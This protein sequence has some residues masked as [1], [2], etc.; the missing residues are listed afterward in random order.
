MGQHRLSRRFAAAIAGGVLGLSAGAASA[1]PGTPLLAAARDD[2]ASS[3]AALL[4]Q[5][6]DVNVRD[7]VGAT[8]LAWAVLRSNPANVKQLLQAGADPNLVDVNGMGPLALA[9]ESDNLE[10]AGLLL[11]KG[12]EPNLPRGAGETPLMSATRLK[13]KAMVRLLLD[14]GASPNAQEKKFGQTA[15]MWAAGEPEIV[16]MLLDKGADIR[17]V[18]RSW[19]VTATRYTPIT[20]TLGLTGIPWNHDGEYTTRAGGYGPLHFA[21]QNADIESVKMLL[22]A[23]ADVNQPAADG[24]TPLLIALFKWVRNGQQTRITSGGIVGSPD[25]NYVS[26]LKLANLLLDRGAKANVASD[27]GYTPLHGAVLGLVMTQPGGIFGLAF[28][29]KRSDPERPRPKPAAND[30]E[31]LPLIRRLLEAGADPTSKTVQPAQGPVNA[32]RTDPTP[33]GS[34]PFHIAAAAHSARLV[35]LMAQH[36]ADPNILRDDGHS[37]FSVAV[38]SNNL[39]VVQAMVAG[40]ADIRQIFN[41]IDEFPD[42]VESKTQQRK[43]Q[44]I[45]HIAGAAGADWTIPYLASQG[46]PVNLRNNLGETAFDIADSQE[47]YRFARMMEGRSGADKDGLKRETQTSALLRR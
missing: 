28:N 27:L 29:P 4:K 38:M 31:Y 20:N 22:D 16:R 11:A 10:I 13:S 46:A 6:T 33:P 47:R 37:P 24:S 19:E 9:I 32:V 42:P 41:T 15:L 30:E 23:G 25:L 1:A 18:S 43:G 14:H 7:E 3:V 2:L 39:P 21:V 12:A 5:R 40:G 17:T 35:T 26:D 34:T 45:L 8:P 44:S 36:R